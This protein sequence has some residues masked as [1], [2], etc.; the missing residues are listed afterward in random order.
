MMRGLLYSGSHPD[1]VQ[2]DLLFIRVK[3][4]VS[5]FFNVLHSNENRYNTVP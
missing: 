5:S 4:A 1:E 3:G 2:I